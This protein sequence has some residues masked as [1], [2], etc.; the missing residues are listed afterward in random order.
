MP[1][2]TRYPSRASLRGAFILSDFERQSLHNDIDAAFEMPR[3]STPLPAEELPCTENDRPS[4]RTFCDNL[5]TPITNPC[6]KGVAQSPRS[7][8]GGHLV[9]AR[10][11]SNRFPAN[12]ADNSDNY[13]FIITTKNSSP[14]IPQDCVVFIWNKITATLRSL[15]LDEDKKDFE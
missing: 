1:E 4:Y 8:I 12:D 15:H 2:K 5:K 10:S 13:Q 7:I 6:V 14:R 9:G 11:C 3:C